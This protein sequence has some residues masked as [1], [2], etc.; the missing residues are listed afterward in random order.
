MLDLRG[1]AGAPRF[2][3]PVA[4]VHPVL[5]VPLFPQAERIQS[6]RSVDREDT[7]EMIDLMLKQLGLVA[8]DIQLQPFA[9]QILITNSDPVRAGDANQEVGKREAVVPDVEVF[10]ADVHD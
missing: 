6:L 1:V 5:T 9:L 3:S 7:I 10:V 2:R 8:F 4:S